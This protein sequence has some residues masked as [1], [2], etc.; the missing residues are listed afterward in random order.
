MDKPKNVPITSPTIELYNVPQ[1]EGRSPN[2]S[3][4]VSQVDVVSKLVP[5][6]ATAG[7]AVQAI[8]S[9]MYVPNA[10]TAHAIAV[11]PIRARRSV[12]ISAELGGRAS[13][14]PASA[15]GSS[16][17]AD[18]MTPRPGYLTLSSAFIPAATT[19]AGSGT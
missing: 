16:R 18:D 1:I 13:D 12:Q 14:D 10:T 2:N 15:R 19:V 5:K 9:T 4:F 17:C 7:R 8:L 11:V 6:R 3:R